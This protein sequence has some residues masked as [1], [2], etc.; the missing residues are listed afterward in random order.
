MNNK[1]K[2]RAH[3][4]PINQ[5]WSVTLGDNIIGIGPQNT[6]FFSSFPTL[7]TVLAECGLNVSVEG[8]ISKAEG[9]SGQYGEAW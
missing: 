5:A 7:R 3:Y 4:M 1:E 9:Y 2:L 6:R 8:F